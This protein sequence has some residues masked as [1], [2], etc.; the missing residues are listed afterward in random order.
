M[1]HHL[2]SLL[3]PMSCNYSTFNSSLHVSICLCRSSVSSLQVLF[4]WPPL[5]KINRFINYHLNYS[6]ALLEGI[7]LHKHF[8]LFVCFQFL[9]RLP[10]CQKT[11][12]KNIQL[13]NDTRLTVFVIIIH[14]AS[15]VSS[16]MMMITH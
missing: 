15:S 13:Q 9:S 11:I 6:A 10:H 16:Q 12:C 7:L 1:C 3:R 5:L 14:N 8:C 4:C 2:F